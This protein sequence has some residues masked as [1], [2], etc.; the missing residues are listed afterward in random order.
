MSKGELQVYFNQGDAELLY[1]L[2]R[3]QLMLHRYD[4]TDNYNLLGSTDLDAMLTVPD[5]F[6]SHDWI[7]HDVSRNRL[8]VG[9]LP[10]EPLTGEVNGDPLAAG[11][12]VLAV[13]T[14]RNFYWVLQRLS[15]VAAVVRVDRT[16]NMV[17]DELPIILE[18]TF[19]GDPEL[20]FDIANRRFYA[21]NPIT[22][23]IDTYNY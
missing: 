2:D 12:V 20:A 4:G 23:I 16:S 17:L 14:L 9:P 1:V 21:A 10:L 19:H 7:Y 8:Y 3:D 15:T 11:H 13:D 5:D 22:T 6:P 18:G